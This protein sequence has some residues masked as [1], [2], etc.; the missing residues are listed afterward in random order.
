MGIPPKSVNIWQLFMLI[1]SLGALALLGIQT[2]VPLSHETRETA[3]IIDTIICGFF[4]MD[5][6]VQIVRT[7]P[8]WAYLRWGWLDLLASI[9]MIPALRVARLAR[10]A[11]IIRVLR[12]ARASRHLLTILLKHRAR[13]TFWAVMLGCVILVMFSTMAIVSVES[14]LSPRDALWWS[15]FTLVTGEYGDFYPGT[16]EGRVITILLMTAGVALFGTFTASM[17][18]YFLEEDQEADE[19]RDKE[20]IARIEALSEKV[21]S[22]YTE[23][24]SGEPNE[25]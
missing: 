2:F 25:H 11:R 18:S 9:P 24:D 20:I 6:S 12:G 7:R 5:F 3:R 8:V 14:T 10:I 13:N 17:A 15:V 16:T 22:L 21:D 4:L 1:I 23:P 19:G